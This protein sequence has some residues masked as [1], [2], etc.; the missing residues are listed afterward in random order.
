MNGERVCRFPCPAQRSGTTSQPARARSFQKFLFQLPAVLEP[1]VCFLFLA[2]EL[3]DFET[4]VHIGL[5]SYSRASTSQRSHDKQVSGLGS[6][7]RREP[8]VHTSANAART[9][10][11]A[12]KGLLDLFGFDA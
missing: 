6:L 2:R 11:R 12:T 10:A 9:S 1:P 8:C 3:R 5:F 7:D 4:I